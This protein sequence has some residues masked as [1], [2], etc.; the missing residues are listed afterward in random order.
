MDLHVRK[1][2]GNLVVS[3]GG[4]LDAVS[5]PEFD[6]RVQEQIKE[7]ELVFVLDL[8]RLVY[9]SSAGLRSILSLA[10]AL[11]AKGGRLTLCGLTDVVKEVFDLSGFTAI[12]TI[13]QS[14][15]QALHG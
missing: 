7:D 3:V 9:I 2:V 5:A 10:K 8:T 11:R 15:D 1:E 4:R 14:L 13:T 6:E 12:L